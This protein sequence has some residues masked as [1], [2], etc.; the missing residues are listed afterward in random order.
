MCTIWLLAYINRRENVSYLSARYNFKKSALGPKS[1]FLNDFKINFKCLHS[2]FDRCSDVFSLWAH[3][4]IKPLQNST[5]CEIC[6]QTVE[7]VWVQKMIHLA[8]NL[9]AW[10]I[11]IR[12]VTKLTFLVDLGAHWEWKCSSAFYNF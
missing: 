8:Q 2:F 6:Y 11:F 4:N 7:A 1:K 12:C 5:G 9:R 10:F 3:N